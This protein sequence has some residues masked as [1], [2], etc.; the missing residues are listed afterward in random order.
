MNEYTHQERSG[1]SISWCY[2]SEGRCQ[3]AEEMF[4]NLPIPG[5]RRRH[6]APPRQQAAIER[7]PYGKNVAAKV[8][9]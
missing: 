3:T 5:T 2:S 1:N 6:I 9:S 4:P 7:I 8:G